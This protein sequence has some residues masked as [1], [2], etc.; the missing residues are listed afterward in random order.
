MDMG[1]RE[2]RSQCHHPRLG[3]SRIIPFLY[4]QFRDPHEVMKVVEFGITT[5]H[6]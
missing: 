4:V 1:S 3:K 2:V 5:P 6:G